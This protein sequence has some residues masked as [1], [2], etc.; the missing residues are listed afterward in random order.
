M[1]ENSDDLREAARAATRC[2]NFNLR[3]ASRALGQVY[4]AALRP[5]GLK[6]TQFS[7]LTAL[8]LLGRVPLSELAREL[9]MDRTS[10]TRNLRPLLRE[11]YVREDRGEDRRQRLLALTEAG[12]RTYREALPLWQAVQDRI[13]D[14]LGSERL[15]RLLSDLAAARRP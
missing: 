3:R 14:R 2:A 7:L 15:E 11:G 10:L 4:D 1:T 8:A 12:R 9:G 5:V 13:E 6:G